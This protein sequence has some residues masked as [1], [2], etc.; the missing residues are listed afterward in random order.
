MCVAALLAHVASSEFGIHTD[1]RIV[2]PTFAVDIECATNATVR[3]VDTDKNGYVYA[4][5][6]CNGNNLTIGAN[7]TSIGE[8]TSDVFIVKLTEDGTQFVNV[9]FRRNTQVLT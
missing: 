2:L 3:A 5:G 4:A 8:M 9:V 1:S 7:L 6:I